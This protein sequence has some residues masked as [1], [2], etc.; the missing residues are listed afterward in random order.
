MAGNTRG[1][2]K[3]HFQ[4]MH[5]NFDWLQFH[6]SECIKLTANRK[7]NLDEAIG[8]LAGLIKELDKHV[9]MLYSTI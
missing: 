1:R 3:E 8:E 6:C 2:L 5:K 7:P 9:M 4:G